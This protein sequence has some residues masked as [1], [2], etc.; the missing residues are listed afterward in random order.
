MVKILSER[1]S[2]KD[3]KEVSSDLDGYVKVVI[4]IKREVLAAGGIRHVQGEEL[5]LADGSAQSDLWGGGL[6]LETGDIDYDSMIN[7]RPDQNNPSREVLD[8]KIRHKMTA[9]LRR[10]LR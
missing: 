1:I 9:I 6:D 4:D 10:L 5:L 3:L 8:M 7:I 2:D